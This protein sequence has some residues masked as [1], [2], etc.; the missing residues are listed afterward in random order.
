MFSFLSP[1][2]LVGAGAAAIPVILHL[3]EREPEARVKFAAVTLLKRAPIELTDKRHLR[4]WLLLALRVT[5][6]LFL[7]IAFARPF[8]ASGAAAGFPGVTVV[9]IDTS[10]SLSAP[11]R[12]ERARQLARDAVKRTPPGD[13]VAVLAF[14]DAAD[15]V[16][17]PSAD[18]AIA[19]SAIDRVTAGFGATRYRAA[20]DTAAQAIGGHTGRHGT[21]VVVTDLQEN[22][23]DAGDRTSVP[24]SLGIVVADVGAPPPN[25]AVTS[26]RVAGDHLVALVRNTDTRRRE[27]RARLTLDGRPAGEQPVTI[28]PQASAEITLPFTSRA[29]TAEVAID[30]RDGLQAD[31]TRYAVLDHTSRPSLLVVTAT[32]D[33][34]RDAFY[35]QQALAATAEAHAPYE[36]SGASP[37]QLGAWDAP[38]QPTSAGR[39]EPVEGR[40]FAESAVLLLSTRGFERRGREAL[41]AYVRGGGGLLI[42]AGPDVDG[43]VIAG[44]LGEGSGLRL[45]SPPDATPVSRAL[46]PADLRHPMFQPFGTNAA[47]IGLVKFK[48]VAGIHGAECQTL[49]RFTSGEPALLDCP[50]GDGHALVLASDLN[51]RWNDFPLHATFVPFLHEAVRYLARARPRADDYLVGD[52]P[53][54]VPRTPGIVSLVPGPREGGAGS[55]HR[56]RVAINVDPREGD[57][58]RVS[59]D[60]LQTAVARL[61]DVGVA[62]ARLEATEREDRQHAWRLVLMAMLVMLALEGVVASRTA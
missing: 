43:E 58:A 3:L 28:G 19:L 34:A 44:V 33:P 49:A 37:A 24:Q 38:R 18:R 40:L 54:G 2:F 62:E 56:R 55:G 17:P 5:A 20:L 13:L 61:Q 57:P 8:L 45:T 48:I 47:S 46:A 4:E 1:L 10:Y 39:P 42:A 50:A 12:I 6:L 35:V 21:I 32:G 7:A 60:E 23:W 25:L 14:A 27:T 26:L 11:G 16:A 15:L 51:N 31:N 59:A 22:G 53:G 41:A 52:A 36:I 9:A 30:D 29:G